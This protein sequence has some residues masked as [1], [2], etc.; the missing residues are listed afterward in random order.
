MSVSNPCSPVSIMSSRKVVGIPVST[1]SLPKVTL[2]HSKMLTKL[3]SR[4]VEKKEV[5]ATKA[6][7]SKNVTT[8]EA[9]C[10]SK[11]SNLK[12]PTASKS[13]WQ[14]AKSF[15]RV[16]PKVM[17]TFREKTNHKDNDKQMVSSTGTE[18]SGVFSDSENGENIPSGPIKPVRPATGSSQTSSSRLASTLGRSTIKSIRRPTVN[19]DQ[20]IISDLRNQ[21]QQLKNQHHDHVEQIKHELGD[22]HQKELA[23]KELQ[24]QKQ[25]ETKEL[26]WRDETIRLVEQGR[27]ETL[28]DAERR[29]EVKVQEERLT[30]QQRVDALLHKVAILVAE[31]E[32]TDKNIDQEV[33]SRIHATVSRYAGL[34]KETSSLQAVFELRCDEVRNL[35][36]ELEKVSASAVECS[37]LRERNHTLLNT[38]EGLQAQLELKVNED[39]RLRSEIGVLTSHYKDEVIKGR[40]LSME[41]E[42]LQY[43]LSLCCP[44]TANESEGNGV[45]RTRSS[46][47]ETP[48]HSMPILNLRL[49]F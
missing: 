20:F 7:C 43:K 34:Q 30:W 25:T 37:A 27:Q 8:A 5:L 26:T 42:E 10:K 11:V 17:T 35:R 48:R 18:S 44:P 15:G 21:I 49:T 6:T 16:A 14:T 24:Y 41:K 9:N 33:E 19:S 32:K 38:V 2:T 4:K 39:R 31:K 36:H 45:T 29:W 46:T 1:S 12:P 23:E 22:K 40:R 13:L 28:A 47:L 3:P